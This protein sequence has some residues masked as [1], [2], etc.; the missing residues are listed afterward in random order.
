MSLED[1]KFTKDHEWIKWNG[2]LALIGITEYAQK[3]LGDI[4]Y[5][6]LP[7]VGDI[8]SKG[9]ACCNV[10]SVKAVS[11]IYSPLVGEITEVN[12]ELEDKPELLNQSPYEAGWIF[13]I[14]FGDEKEL[15][16]YMSNTEYEEYLAGIS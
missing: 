12:K 6:E 4:V 10:E 2:D 14:K 8:F 16:E 11:D 1:L 3:E 15:A 13:K 9:E 5:V 7:Q